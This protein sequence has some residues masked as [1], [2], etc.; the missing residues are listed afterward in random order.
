[1]RPVFHPNNYLPP[2]DDDSNDGNSS[3]KPEP[4]YDGANS[5]IG[6]HKRYG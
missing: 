2:L 1:V 6:K 4:I 5:L 3:P